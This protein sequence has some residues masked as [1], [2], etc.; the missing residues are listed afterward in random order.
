METWIWYCKYLQQAFHRKERTES[1]FVLTRGQFFP[2]FHEICQIMMKQRN[3]LPEIKD[4]VITTKT[5]GYS[6]RLLDKKWQLDKNLSINFNTILKVLPYLY[7]QGL[8]K[9]LAFYASTK[10]AGCVQGKF[11]SFQHMMRTTKAN[12]INEVTLINF[13][14]GQTRNNDTHLRSIRPFLKKWYELG[15]PGVTK[16]V[17]DLLY[18]WKL[19]PRRTGEVVKR[20]DP[21]AGPLTDIELQA[22]NEGA[23]LAFEQ[24]LIQLMELAISLGASHTGRRPIQLA[25]LRVSDVLV[26]ENNKKNDSHFIIKIPRVKQG[27]GLRES[28]KDF[29]ASKELWT[30]LSAQARN[31]ICLVEEVL[32]FQL[33]E[34]DRGKLPLFPDLN[35]V[36]K[37]SSLDT[38]REFLV[39]DKLQIKTREITKI[40]KSVAKKAR[41]W[42]ERTG[43]ALN[44]HARR[45]RYTTGTR[46]AREGF[47]RLII[48]ELLDHSTIESADVYVKNIPEHAKFIDEAVSDQLAPYAKAFAGSLVDSTNRES[49]GRK[50]ANRIRNDEGFSVGACEELGCCQANVPIPCYTCIHF[51]AWTD[52]PHVDVY[53]SLLTERERLKRVT[54]DIEIAAVL[55]RSILAVAEVIKKCLDVHGVK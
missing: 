10:S 21:M 26:S 13:R 25:L 4:E 45:F 2:V 29:R 19:K 1:C 15:Y 17:I 40:L 34:Q 18:K 54:G 5:P 8:L 41:V 48:A 36:S 46:A 33:D 22:F 44:I 11:Y 49:Q 3:E 53:H 38:F 9:T 51:Q 52:G 30:I 12:R 35:V 37:I 16:E 20:L 23:V 55:D 31:S 6:F 24:N 14:G 50:L 42:S 39:T 28:F 32:P 7:H 43:D 27:A 47:G